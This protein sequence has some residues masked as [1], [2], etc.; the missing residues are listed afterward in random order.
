MTEAEVE[1]R[2]GYAAI[3]LA[4]GAG[5]RFGGGKLLAPWRGAA[6]VAGAVRAALATG[7]G[8]VIVVTGTDAE[9]VGKACET[10]AG[11]GARARLRRVHAEDHAEGMGASLRTGVAALPPDIRGV[12]VFLGDMPDIPTEVFAPLVA[13]V[14]AG[15]PAA[16]PNFGG[17]R[18]H[19]VLFSAAL[20]P[21]LARASG[22]AGAR[23]VLA[24]LGD[25]VARVACAHPGVLFDVD[26]PEDLGDAPRG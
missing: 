26:R 18:G 17:R 1:G 14:E 7:V 25:R 9:A 3:V 6:L 8:P 20:L 16:A 4:A 19:P 12:F 15:A 23:E 11:P 21:V 5:R 10:A 24:R 22:D 2:A 13:A